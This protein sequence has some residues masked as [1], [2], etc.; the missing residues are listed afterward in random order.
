[1]HISHQFMRTRSSLWYILMSPLLFESQCF[2]CNSLFAHTTFTL[3]LKPEGSKAFLEKDSILVGSVFTAIL[4][5]LRRRR[6][7]IKNC[8]PTQCD[9]YFE[10][11]Y[12]YDISSFPRSQMKI[13]ET[14]VCSYQQ[15]WF[16]LDLVK[17]IATTLTETRRIAITFSNILVRGEPATHSWNKFTSH[18]FGFFLS[19]HLTWFR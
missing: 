16:C 14:G 10:R 19:K 1:M 12:N 15:R 8:V 18:S 3:Q 9:F 11:I 4:V 7:D 17:C 5:P 6:E 13:W 2:R